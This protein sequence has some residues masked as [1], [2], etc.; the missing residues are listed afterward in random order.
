M[1]RGPRRAENSHCF[2]NG[3]PGA[4]IVAQPRHQLDDI[5][6]TLIE[7]A[8]PEERVAYLDR[9]CG[10][11]V[12]LRRRVER[13][14]AAHSQ[15]GSFLAARP[16][17][18]AVTQDLPAESPGLVI[19]PY[20]LLQVIGEGGMGTVWMAEQLQP[21]HRKVALKIIKADTDR[22]TVLARFEAER[23]ALA[24]MDHPNIAKVLDAGATTTGRPYFVMELVKGDA[25]TKY[26]DEHRLTP[27]QRLELFMPVCQAIQ[28]AHQKGIIH[29]DIKPSNVLV[30]PYD[31]KP[32]VKVIDFGVAKATGQRLT[33]KTLFTEF[34]AVVGTLEYM[35]PEQAEL[36][37]H[38]ID[39]RSD[40]YS[41]GVLLYELL[42][43]S[44]PLQKSRFKKAAMMEVL[45]LIREEE[46]PRPST[47]LSTTDELPSVAANRG[48]E[49]KKLSG[50]VR[51]ELDWI[52]MKAL[53][54]DR[55]R[56]YE[57][58]NSF[59]LDVQRF[60]ADE[61]VQACPPSTW[62]RV[63]KFARRHKAPV[64]AASL[65]LTSLILGLIG[66]G[67][68]LVQ[69][70]Q[71]RQAE[72]DAAQDALDKK[73]DAERAA[74]EAR[75]ANAAAQKRLEQLEK[76]NRVLGS[77]FVDLNPRINTTDGMLRTLLGERL[78][79]AVRQLN[80]EAV[81]DPLTVA[82]LQ[83]T[84]A[85]SLTSLGYA[86]KA[87]GLLVEAHKTFTQQ[88]GP[89]DADTLASL[90]DLALT[91]HALARY[92]DAIKLHEEALT[93]RKASFGV[94]QR[95]TLVT[96]TNLAN[97][98]DRAGRRKDAL[99][100]REE[101]L[102]LRQ[103]TL[104]PDHADT[105]LSMHN[106]ANS[107]EHVGRLQDAL[108]LRER[109]LAGRRATLGTKHYDTLMT[110]DALGNSY[111]GLG[112]AAEA[113]K[114]REEALTLNRAR[115]GPDHP[116][117]LVAMQNVA[118]T[119]YALSRHSEAA[120]L[121]EETLSGTKAKLAPDHPQTLNCMNG[122]AACYVELDRPRDALELFEQV[123]ALRRT[124][125]GPKHADTLSSMNNLAVCYT[126]VGRQADALKVYEEVLTIQR[127][128]VGPAHPET[129]A[130]MHNL[131]NAYDANGRPAD[132]LKLREETF[133]L[134][135][136]TFGSDH[137]QTLQCMRS[138]G[139][140]YF[141]FDRHPEALKLREEMLIRARK[142]LGREHPVTLNGLQDLAES[143]TAFR[144]HA[145]ALKLR[146]EL[147]EVRKATLGPAHLHTLRA[148]HDLAISLAALGRHPEALKIREEVVAGRKAKLGGDHPDTLASMTGLANS[149]YALAKHPEALK[150]REE[151]L[152]IEKTKLG[153]DH[154]STLISMHN[155]ANS[156]T[157]VERFNDA[158]KLQEETLARRKTKLG[159]SHPRTLETM[160][161]LAYSLTRL[162]R[163]ADAVPVIDDCLERAV[164][165]Q[166][167][168]RLFFVLMDMR[169]R[170]F[171]ARKDPAGCRQC[172]E[173]WEKLKRPGAEA[174]YRAAC[175]RAVA[176]GV[177]R[178]ADQS[179][180]AVKQADADADRAIGWL[181]QAIAAG[182]HNSAQL[183]KD[184]D[185]DAVREHKDFKQLLAEAKS[186]NQP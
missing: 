181:K 170:H 112:R 125:L 14:L 18:A 48:M 118:I 175:I 42:T 28:H 31:G 144:R 34:G 54:K 25:I 131:A 165:K 70:D 74:T 39:T 130:T 37:N 164:G 176:A 103:V 173:L 36:N 51:G 143:Y 56:R 136:T 30:A 126:M 75:L 60:L 134:M 67:W 3:P 41:L 180:A 35:S 140:N 156:Y 46:A 142:K 83:A 154:P 62:Y 64:L 149:Y 63:R 115:L 53:E 159:A 158:L 84:L 91:Y 101:T 79:N 169:L 121:F 38:D 161:G 24:L 139:V 98:Y 104:G 163:G 168:P 167:D 23:Q 150:L 135:M 137:V 7:L 172:A 178:A 86:K 93:V 128:K 127:D 5:F 92:A 6:C 107:Y 99:Q 152:A 145:E 85:R 12:D 43:G 184:R 113:L 183:A 148:L 94:D 147:V 122:L 55:N 88:S 182:Y 32:V 45:R 111:A 160:W 59:A 2:T 22:H 71:A 50:I 17:V 40:I 133:P 153:P 141:A 90:S 29:R 105:L 57:T 8:S 95:D 109:T 151:V 80:G 185:L 87:I 179:P 162:D 15:A 116:V 138:L 110:M 129:L 11:D 4:E 114:L 65:V 82:R 26:C 44:T 33:E 117:T 171:A 21:V 1:V 132:A 97:S 100:L 19:G 106:L 27:R 89:E 108:E 120:K 166:V 174:L 9:A 47:R 72:A 61:P 66:T 68:G 123:A 77:V 146:E 20:K 52:A 102:K 78:D 16:A 157:A 119:L 58:A 186:K 49:P 10:S 96:M 73:A 76:G 81:G 155:L 177:L 13:L 124:K 69:A